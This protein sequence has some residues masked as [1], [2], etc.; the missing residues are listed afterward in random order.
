MYRKD[1]ITAFESKDAE[2]VT[3]FK[4]LADTLGNLA[5]K[6]GNEFEWFDKLANKATECNFECGSLHFILKNNIQVN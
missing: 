6:P 5:K 3:W 1:L 4:I 2:K